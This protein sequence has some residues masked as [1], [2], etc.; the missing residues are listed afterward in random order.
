MTECAAVA[1]KSSDSQINARAPGLV[2]YCE[3]ACSYILH[4][5]WQSLAW[6]ISQSMKY[7]MEHIMRYHHNRCCCQPQLPRYYYGEDVSLI[8]SIH[9]SIAFFLLA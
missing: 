6:Y 8:T 5:K 2:I 3:S 1:A 4:N 7:F 9:V